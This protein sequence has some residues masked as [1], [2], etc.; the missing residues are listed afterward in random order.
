MHFKNVSFLC[1]TFSLW[2]DRCS[3]GFFKKKSL[4]QYRHN[5][6]E[7]VC[8]LLA[9]PS[10]LPSERSSV[11]FVYPFLYLVFSVHCQNC[12]YDR[13]KVCHANLVWDIST[14]FFQAEKPSELLE[15]F[16]R[17]AVIY[18]EMRSLFA[19]HHQIERKMQ[20]GCN[21]WEQASKSCSRSSPFKMAIF[22]H[23]CTVKVK[24]KTI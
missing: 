4:Y 8:I 10:A 5:T 18:E 14:D 3:V 2:Y 1:C 19:P 11:L 15:R 22:H 17:W 20:F 23:F 12:N 7:L 6:V 21:A 16:L 9:S 13:L 24:R